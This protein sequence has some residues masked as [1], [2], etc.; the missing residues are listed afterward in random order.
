MKN[1]IFAGCAALFLCLTVFT[2]TALALPAA[3]ANTYVGDNA[4]V[5]SA[6]TE[7]HILAQNK[8]LHEATGGA[9]VVVT[10]DFMDGMDSESFA[11]EL[12]NTWGIGDKERNNGLLLVYAVGENKVRALQGDGISDALTSSKLGNF[13][14]DYF[15]GDYDAGQYDTA[16]VAFFDAAYDWYDSYY[17]GIDA[18]LAG[19]TV[20]AP[21]SDQ[22]TVH[23]E[24]HYV[25]NPFRIF[26]TILRVGLLI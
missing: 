17:G 14:E 25:R 11:Y 3:P 8:K 18:I 12:F 9:I 7:E 20:A 10:V 13:L 4:D 16:T 21:D 15:Y 22:N 1:R 5:L 2:Q 19:E 24:V 26:A 6:E 23:T